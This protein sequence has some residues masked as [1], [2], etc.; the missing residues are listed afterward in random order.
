[1][2]KKIL[3]IIFLLFFASRALA[4]SVFVETPGNVKAGETFSALIK[5]DT[6]E[7]SINSIN[8]VLSYDKDLLVFSGYKEDGLIKLWV[9]PPREENGKI[10]FGGII[11]GGVTGVYD[12]RQ[13]GLGAIPL[14]RLLFTGKAAGSANF[15]ITESLLLKNDGKGS[16]LTHTQKGATLTIR[17]NPNPTEE[18]IADRNPPFPFDIEIVESSLFS[19]TPT[20]LIFDTSDSDSGIKSYEIRVSGR[21]WQE[22]KSPAPVSRGIFSREISIGAYD[23]YG[24]FQEASI[25]VPGIFSTKLLLTIFILILSGILGYKVLKS[26][27]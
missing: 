9:D 18:K 15:F 20:L 6:D 17:E 5:A 4:A 26:K 24:S 2:K 19:R 3:F 10:Y 22:V 11:P 12:P 25:I 13:E 21:D 14:I 23:F 16:L 7:I 8:V 27:T 1:M